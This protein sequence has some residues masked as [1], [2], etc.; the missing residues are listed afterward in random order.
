MSAS[1]SI[2]GAAPAQSPAAAPPPSATTPGLLRSVAYPFEALASAYG[3]LR[4][5][6]GLSCPGNFENLHR[7]IKNTLPTLHMIEGAKFDVTSIMSQNFQ[8]SHSFTW[9]SSQAPPGYSFIAGYQDGGVLLN[10]QVDHDGA[11][12]GR[13]HLNWPMPSTKPEFYAG[14]APAPPPPTAADSADAKADPGP[15]TPPTPP[16]ATRPAAATKVQLQLSRKMGQSM[17][18]LEHDHVGDSL[19]WNVK[20]INPNPFEA[21]SRRPSPT[22]AAAGRTLAG[23]VPLTTSGIF[24]VS[25]MQSVTRSLALGADVML[26]RLRPDEPETG[27]TLGARWAPPPPPPP[28]PSADSTADGASTTP[29]GALPAPSNMP[30]GFPSPYMPVNPRDPVQVL[31]ATFSPTQGML[32]GSYWRRINQRLEV[33]TEVQMLLTPA[34]A[35]EGGGG[36]AGGGPAGGR[37]IAGAS[38]FEYGRREAIASVGFKLDTVYATIRSMIDSMGRVTTVIE[39][40]MSP[41][42]SFQ[43]AGELDYSKGQGGA[44]RVGFGFTLEA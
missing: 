37:T 13:A 1:P 14:T 3:T 44:G 24:S 43:I 25:F 16:V 8:V 42:L 22:G 17:V 30:P 7:E 26:Q 39:E 10:G 9:G 5:R 32:H 6:Q 40:R 36:G 34:R 19:A 21:A 29:D 4:D 33:A 31:S 38:G 12:N 28:L 11:L 15:P 18:Q 2:S 20:A 35:A 27:L 41:G 23:T